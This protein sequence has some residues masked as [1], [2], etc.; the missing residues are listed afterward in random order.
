VA[1]A[2]PGA[3]V[4]SDHLGGRLDER[5]LLVGFN[6]WYRGVIVNKVDG[7]SLEDAT[8]VM[9]PTGL[10]PLGIV[11]HLAA[12]EV[13]W[14]VETFRGDPVDPMWDDYGEF[15]LRGDDTVESVLAMYATSC[16]RARAVVDRAESLDALSAEPHRFWGRVTLR[17]VLLHMLEETARH[18]GHLDLMREELDGATG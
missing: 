13:G 1:D 10:S 4:T 3:R 6:D 16:D 15:Q 2:P 9:T 7:L 12:C 18:A 14:Y 11:A 8:R 17:W 5:G